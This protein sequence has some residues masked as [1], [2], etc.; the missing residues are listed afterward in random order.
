MQTCGQT[1]PIFVYNKGFEGARIGDLIRHLQEEVGLVAALAAIKARLV[2][3]KPITQDAY[4][5]PI[6]R[7]SWSIKANA[8]VYFQ[9]FVEVGEVS[10]LVRTA[11]LTA[12]DCPA[13]AGFRRG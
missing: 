6:Q 10:S 2:D 7:G 3:L 4:Y 13:N 5:N 11:A 8:K 9:A 12:L 1:G